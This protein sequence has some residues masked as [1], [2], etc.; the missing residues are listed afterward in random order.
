MS[1]GKYIN[2]TVDKRTFTVSMGN[3]PQQSGAAL[4]TLEKIQGIVGSKLQGTDKYKHCTDSQRDQE[5]LATA[6]L[7]RD[8]YIKKL[9]F[10]KRL[11]PSRIAVE[12]KYREIEQ[13]A[14]KQYLNITIENGKFSTSEDENKPVKHGAAL[15]TLNKIKRIMGEELQ[16]SNEYP[17]LAWQAKFIREEYNRKADKLTLL[18]RFLGGVSKH[19]REITRV[20][21]AIVGYTLRKDLAE[22]LPKQIMSPKDKRKHTLKYAEEFGYKGHDSDHAVEYCRVLSNVVDLLI[23][24]K[25]IPEKYVVKKS[26]VNIPLETIKEIQNMGKIDAS[27]FYTPNLAEILKVGEHFSERDIKCLKEYIQKVLN[28]QL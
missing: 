16:G 13:A 23:D 8:S 19:Q 18:R 15:A 20:Y 10:F 28:V 1:V 12:A 9:P 7:I 5:L 22:D 3:K 4:D 25:C 2:V 17:Q 24:E 6:K 27:I 11:F 21:N 26:G 14:K